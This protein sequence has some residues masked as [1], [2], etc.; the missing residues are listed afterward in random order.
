MDGG[1]AISEAI[2]WTD[3]PYN[4]MRHLCILW[5]A[6]P[7]EPPDSRAWLAV[8]NETAPL[9]TYLFLFACNILNVRFV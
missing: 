6:R 5:Q 9:A 1:G 4:R 7:P 2:R 8:L 3:Y